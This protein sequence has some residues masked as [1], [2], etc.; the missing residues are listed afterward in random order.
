MSVQKN[1]NEKPLDEAFNAVAMASNLEALE[2]G[3]TCQSCA[4]GIAAGILGLTGFSG[5]ILYFATV[6]LQGLIWS[7]K[8]S[9]GWHH[10]FLENSQFTWSHGNG[11]L[12]F[13]LLWVFFY[14]MVHVY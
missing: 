13:V 12:T 6:V 3:R 14:G 9:G 1:K 2:F 5:F 4:A 7:A 11:L 10:Y 8:A